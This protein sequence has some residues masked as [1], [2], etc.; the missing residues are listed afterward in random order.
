MPQFSMDSTE[1]YKLK[2]ERQAPPADD[3]ADADREAWWRGAVIYQVYPRS[4]MDS[5]SD[6]IGDLRGVIDKLGYIADLGVDAVWVSPFFSSPMKDFGYDVSDYRRVD[7][8]FGDLED[9]DRLVDGAHRA[10]L[11]LIIDQVLSHSSDQH[12]WFMESRTSRNNARANWYV[13]ADPRPDGTAP[14]NWLSVFGGSAWQWEPQ[15]EQYYLH[16]FLAS[17][18]DLNYHEP[19]VVRQMLEEVR[20]WLERGVDGLRLDAINFC[21]HDPRLRDNPAKP[22]AER[23]GR[24]YRA[25]NPYAWQ[26]HLYDNTQPE[27][28][29][30]LE[31]LRS[32]SDNYSDVVLLGEVTGENPSDTMLEYTSGCNRLHMAYNFELLSDDFSLEHIRQAVESLENNAVK[33]WPCRSIGNHDVARVTTRWAGAGSPDARAKLL[34]ALLLSLKGSVCSYQGDELGL[35]QAVIAP[36]DIRDPYGMAF[37]PL[38]QGRDGCRTPMPWT[39]SGAASGFTGGKP[40]LPVPPEHREKAVEKQLKDPDSVLQAYR[41]F[42]RWRRG[43][44]AF[45]FG[46]IRFL[47]SPSETIAFVREYGADRVLAIF[48][49]NEAPVDYRTPL[50]LH[51]EK[52][53]GHGFEPASVDDGSVRLPGYT[54]W[55]ARLQ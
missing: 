23:V 35:T 48:N 30:F 4:F 38:F 18:P 24:G 44:R 10:G 54:A 25:D 37:W 16:N 15:R 7:P 41:G 31:Q 12:P 29:V 19:A 5:N 21:Y 45:R 1:S 40:W 11:R 26:Y 14:N 27:N 9:F 20:F 42:V 47:D 52:L 13:W 43:Q 6:G 46:D 28:I 53:D 3:L 22:K 34:N 39:G 55:F 33:C 8:I 32:L 17:Q 50:L 49:F 51:S 2:T 36:E